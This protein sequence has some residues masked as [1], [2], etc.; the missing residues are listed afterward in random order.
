MKS[1]RRMTVDPIRS[2]PIWIAGIKY[3]L[4]TAVEACVDVAQHIAGSQR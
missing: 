3:W 4:V 1:L 2:D